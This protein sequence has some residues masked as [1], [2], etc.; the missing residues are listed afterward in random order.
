MLEIFETDWR[1]NS[2]SSKSTVTKTSGLP[3]Q[4]VYLEVEEFKFS[5]T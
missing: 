2:H 3:N 4:L 5:A 1:R